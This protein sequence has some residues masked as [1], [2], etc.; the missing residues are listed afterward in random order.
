MNVSLSIDG[1]LIQRGTLV[2]YTGDGEQQDGTFRVDDITPENIITLVET[3]EHNEKYGYE[4]IE[5]WWRRGGRLFLVPPGY[6]A[7]TRSGARFMTQREFNEGQ[8]RMKEREKALAKKYHE[9]RAAAVSRAKSR[10][11][12]EP[13]LLSDI[14]EVVLKR[15]FTSAFDAVAGEYGRGVAAGVASAATDAAREVI[16]YRDGVTSERSG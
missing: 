1:Y 10:L 14:D 7:K 4:H 12:F 6:F 13:E 15:V 8:Q 11:V 3:T 9:A 5:T 16:R 2:Y